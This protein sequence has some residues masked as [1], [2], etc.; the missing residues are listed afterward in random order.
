MDQHPSGDLPSNLAVYITITT[1]EPEEI[2]QAGAAQ[3]ISL[4]YQPTCMFFAE[5]N[6]RL[7]T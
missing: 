4:N 6:Q 2:G 7:I 3:A 5:S 1:T